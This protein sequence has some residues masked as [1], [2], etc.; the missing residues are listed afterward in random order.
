LVKQ[1]NVSIVRYPGGNFVSGYKWTDGIGP[2]ENRPRR[3]DYAWSSI[4]TNEVGI[5]EFV[6]WCKKADVK[7]MYAVNLGTGTPQDA[8]YIVEYC[9]FPSGT[10]YSDLRRKMGTNSHII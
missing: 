8:G 5:D 7:L 10:F 1:L 3:L 6:D 2:K 9:N 4:E